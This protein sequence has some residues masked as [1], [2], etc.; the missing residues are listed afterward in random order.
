MLFYLIA[1]EFN[2]NSSFQGPFPII[3]TIY[4]NGSSTGLLSLVH[5]K[6]FDVVIGTLSLQLERLKFL[7]G[8]SFYM[9]DSSILTMPPTTTISPFEKLYMPFDVIIWSLI[10]FMCIIGI[11]I[12]TLT[13]LVSK[14]LYEFI[15]GNKVQHPILNMLIAFVGTTQKFLPHGTFSRFLLAK[16]LIFCLVMR[17]LYQG[18]L[19]DIMHRN[20]YEKEAKTINEL[21]EKNYYFYTY[22]SLSRR[23]QGFKFTK[24]YKLQNSKFLVFLKLLYIFFFRMIVIPFAD[25]EKYQLKTLDPFFDGVVFSYEAQ[26]LYHNYLNRKRFSFITC[27]ERLVNNQLVFYLQKNH[28]LAE[29]FSEKIEWF[30]EFGISNHIISKYVNPDY[31]RK[32]KREDVKEPLKFHELTATFGLWLGGLVLGCIILALE[33]I[34]NSIKSQKRKIIKTINKI[35]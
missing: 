1:D 12:I 28:Y 24:R 33:I 34:I 4:N 23:V 18:K 11:L 29:E 16:F 6:K 31:L 7:S 35:V 21:I 26:V 10:I 27:K 22:E 17:G 3:G 19:F 15:V 13:R 14:K 32:T 8:T 20:I 25:I 2:F 30:R 9:S 5:E